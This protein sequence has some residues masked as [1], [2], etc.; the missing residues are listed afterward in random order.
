M[1]ILKTEKIGLTK[2]IIK[3]IIPLEF[4][5]AIILENNTTNPPII[6]IVEMLFVMLSDIISPRLNKLT[7]FK[8][9]ILFELV[10]K[11]LLADFIFQNLKITPTV[12]HANKCVINNKNPIVVFRNIKIPTVPMIN[13]GPEL[14][15][16]L[17]NLSHSS[18]EQIFFSLKVEAILAP[19]GYPLIIPIIRAKEPSP[20]ILNNGFIKGLK[21]KPSILIIFVCINSSVDT[22]NGKSEGTTDVAQSERP[23]F[24][25]IRLSFE[26]NKR[27]MINIKN[28]KAKKHFLNFIT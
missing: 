18:F 24:T 23:D 2:V 6:R 7:D 3:F 4:N 15:V 14:F 10:K 8:L 1:S 11:L 16:K 17:S 20:L 25:A 22:K 12:I 13:N 21:N 28:K 9:E 19:I 26:N 27:H 5:I